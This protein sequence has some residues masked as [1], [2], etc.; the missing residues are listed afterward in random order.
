MS[1]AFVRRCFAKTLFLKYLEN[2]Q[3]RNCDRVSFLIKWQVPM[4]F[5]E[6]LFYRTPLLTEQLWTASDIYST[7]FR[8]MLNLTKIIIN[9]LNEGALT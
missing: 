1:E 7:I 8:G 3:E 4:Q 6:P 2:L 9:E 5:Q